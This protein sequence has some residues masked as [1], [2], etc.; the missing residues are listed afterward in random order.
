MKVWLLRGVAFVLITSG[1]IALSLF[2]CTQVLERGPVANRLREDNARELAIA[3]ELLFWLSHSSDFTARGRFSADMGEIGGTYMLFSEALEPVAGNGDDPDLRQLVNV[4]HEKQEFVGGLPASLTAKGAWEDY[5][6]PYV[7]P[8]GKQYYVA[9]SV[10]EHRALPGVDAAVWIAARLLALGVAGGIVLLL[11]RASEHPAREMRKALRRFAHGEYDARV[12]VK[13]IHRG[14]ELAKLAYEFNAM[15]ERMGHLH[16][17]Q[18]RLFGELS[19]EMRSP[20]SRMALAVELAGRSGSPEVVRLLD[21]IRRDADRLGMLT[22]EML[23][24]AR[25]QDISP[26]LSGRHEG[27]SFS[28]KMSLDVAEILAQVVQDARF[29]AEA[30]GKRVICGELPRG[31]TVDGMPEL[32]HRMVENVLR[33][34]IR[35]TPP[36]TAVT[37]GL[38]CGVRAGRPC[39]M[40]RVCDEGPGVR[41]DELESIFQPFVRGSSSR[42]MAVGEN[43]EPPAAMEGKGLGLSISRHVAIR[44]GGR[45]WAENMHDGGFRVTM[46]LPLV[47]VPASSMPSPLVLQPS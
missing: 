43:S 23:E 17:E 11:A 24:L 10:E 7:A 20:L 3:G 9:G 1:T 15:A 4:A 26:V 30:A 46:R 28:E 34:A 8:D 38:E 13:H 29:E 42:E 2:F 16:A 12:S 44:H 47:A 25:A 39:A 14:D 33:N 41:E 27:V 36:G 37:V 45:V 5:A 19:H 32:L 35:H 18:H 21:R 40:I 6:M 22:N 31:L